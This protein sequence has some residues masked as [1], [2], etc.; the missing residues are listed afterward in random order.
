MYMHN[1]CAAPVIFND[2]YKKI[3]FSL[4]HIARSFFTAI[5]H[6]FYAL[7][8]IF[9]SLIAKPLVGCFSCELNLIS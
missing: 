2:N 6:K 1:L 7:Y 4:L 3:Y 5:F 9:M 8:Y